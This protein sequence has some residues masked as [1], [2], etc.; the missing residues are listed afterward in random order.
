MT[1][2]ELNAPAANPAAFPGDD[3]VMPFQLDRAGMRGR[4][5][6]LDHTLDAI[7]SQ[8]DY[9]GAVAALV[10]EAVLLTAM[11][12]QTMKLRWRFSLQ[13]RGE[14]AI[15]LIATDYFAPTAEG[16]PARVR[17]YAGFDAEALTPKAA[18][19]SLLGA[20]VMG[21]TI[22]QG[23]GMAPYQ[24]LTPLSGA[25]LSASME[26][27]FAQSEQLATRFMIEAAQSASPGE[28]LSWRGGGVMIQQMPAE[29]GVAPDGPSG[30]DR[31]MSAEDVASIAG[32]EEDWGRV[33]MLLGTVETHELVGPFVAPNTLL[34]R[35]FHEELPRVW[36][37]Q[38]V[39]FGCTCSEERV[40]AALSQY[41]SEDIAEMTTP[42][43]HV[44]ADCQFCGASYTLDPAQLGA[45]E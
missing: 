18:P 27:Y 20:G 13:I 4:V 41:S 8:H 9:P 38:E 15:R 34:L 14:G 12:G 29:G 24:G 33:T 17:A 31:L 23:P 10:S 36:P 21:V 45:P 35:L 32:R 28:P 16:G 3:S 37:A 1:S 2:D 26:T 11:I 43:G 44:A 22:D 40:A 19:F 7:L 5:A 42:E 30:E 25:S 6:R 39:R